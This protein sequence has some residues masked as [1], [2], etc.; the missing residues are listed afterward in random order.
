MSLRNILK[1]TICLF[2]TILVCLLLANSCQK[3]VARPPSAISEFGKYEGYSK[4]IYNE[5]IRSSQYLTMRDGVKLAVDIIRPVKDGNAEEKALPVIWNYY[6]YL[7]AQIQDGQVI[8]MVDRTPYLQTLVRHGYVIAIV[9]S[10]GRGVS[11]GKTTDPAS[12][13]EAKDGYEITEWLADQS[14]SDGNVGMFGHS[15][16]AIIQFLVASE[17]PPHLKALFP[18]MGGFDLYQLI[19]PGGI[20]R[21]IIP[22]LVS[23]NF[24]WQDFEAD[25][26]PVGEDKDGAILAKAREQHKNNVDFHILSSLPFQN[27]EHEISKPW[28]LN[29][30]VTHIKE[31]S[32]SSIPIYQWAGWF[33]L[34]C[35]DAFYYF[36][37]L[38]NPQKLVV[39][40]W[41]H[42]DAD[43]TLRAE[44]QKLY[45]TELL[46]WF[47]YWLK[48]IDNGIMDEAAIVYSIIKES[49]EYTWHSTET[50]PL[51]Q[52]K[53]TN[54]YFSEG[55]SKSI[56]SANDGRL[57]EEIPA[58]KTT[59]DSY[60]ANYSSSHAEDH[61]PSGSKRLLSCPNMTPND[62]KGLTYTS[63][64]LDEDMTVIGSPVVTLYLSSTSGDGNFYVY[65]EEI[66][67][68]GKSN[69]I[70]D[71][72]LRASHRK[73]SKPPFDNMSLP[74]HSHFKE[75]AAPI[76]KGEHVNLV[77]ALM[78]ASNVFNK[79]HR[80]RV[81]ITCANAGWDELLEE[82]PAPI[83][84]IYRDQQEPSGISLPIIKE[85]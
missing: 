85:I 57:I 41:E 73:V 24:K 75:D 1:R 32:S 40:P 78:P 64:P 12:M 39:G 63:P 70:T 19:Y 22:E 74:F 2:L 68:E 28:T 71:G 69:L 36:R 35:P 46:R 34:Y 29:N 52:S 56:S 67:Q 62:R 47:D 50:W 77:F 48:G 33:D 20:H 13:V 9:D 27:S 15:Y 17:A 3:D 23:D 8:S 43:S 80:I 38:G 37:N 83:I 21:Q 10:R 5:W 53:Y 72:C 58:S 25:F 16:S 66:D 51:P 65:L 84:T 18:S 59:L 26:V 82:T 42:Y 11:F 55:P 31:I 7:R 6:S 79:G 81:T 14:W 44:R 54:Y 4:P 45:T 30:P 49:G 76:P 61:F 60:T